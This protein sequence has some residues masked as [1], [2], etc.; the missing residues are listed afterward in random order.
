MSLFNELKRRNVFKVGIAYIVVAWLAAQVLQLIFESF[1]TPDWVMKTV[2]VLMAAGLLFALFFAWAFEMTPEGLKREHEVD[3]TQSI[4]PQTGKKLNHLIFAVMA[5]AIVYLAYDKLVLSASR[6]AALIEATTQAVTEQAAAETSAAA[7]TAMADPSTVEPDR[8]IAVLPFADMSPNKDQEYFSDGLSEELLNLLARVPELKV[9]ARTSSFSLKGKEMQ[10]AE[11]GEI[12]K[13]AHVLEGSV[14][15][16]GNRVRITAQLIHAEDGYHLWSET[17][18]RTLDDVFAIQ[19]EIA[20]TVVA[21]LKVTLLGE[22]PQVQETDPAAYA[23]FLQ[24]RHLGRQLTAEGSTQSTE[25]YQQALAI[26]PNYAAAWAGLAENYG[27]QA[28]AGIL[29]FE[30][31]YAMAREAAEKSLTLDPS[32][33]PAYATL[34]YVADSLMDLPAAAEYYQRGLALEPANLD[35]LRKASLLLS[36]LGHSEQSLALL[37]YVNARDPVSPGSH[38]SLGMAYLRMGRWDEAIASFETA[39]RLSPDMIGAR[40]LIGTALLLKGEPEAALA[41]VEQEEFEAYRLLGLVNVYHA[42]GRTELSD[43]ALNEAI[44]KNEQEWAYNIAYVLAYRNEA[45]RAFEWLDKAVEYKDPGL[46]DIVGQLE[47]ANIHDDPRW[48]P[49]LESIGRSP[50]QLGAIEFEV[51]L[52]Q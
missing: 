21:Q 35:M 13:V 27:N 22:A 28:S 7:P 33:A 18:D 24:A 26:D 40:N 41:A 49:F 20:A 10:I 2:L 50:A 38:Y 52:P 15:T 23:L 48:L 25:L 31:G 46:S 42:L 8:S 9:A 12:L 51:A 47:F 37:E 34:G 39:L 1:G 5:L 6:D 29:P 44:D 17:Y 11:V 30:E 19:D 3:R 36:S 4:T 43:A 32:Y 16:A 14:R 45:D